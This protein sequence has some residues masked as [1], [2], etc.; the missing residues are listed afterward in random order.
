MKRS[1]E[2][3]ER[4][5]KDFGDVKSPRGNLTYGTLAEAYLF[6]VRNL[7]IHLTQRSPEVLNEVE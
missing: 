4:V 2:L 7:A 3:F 1:E 5:Q 6:E